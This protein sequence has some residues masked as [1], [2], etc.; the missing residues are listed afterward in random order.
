MKVVA[1]EKRIRPKSI[2]STELLPGEVASYYCLGGIVYLMGTEAGA[3][4]LAN[5]GERGYKAGELPSSVLVG[6]ILH[7]AELHVEEL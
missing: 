6:G 4:V 7:E 3:V 1:K 2:S 5:T